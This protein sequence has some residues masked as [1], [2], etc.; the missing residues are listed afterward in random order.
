[1]LPILDEVAG[2]MA[3]SMAGSICSRPASFG[4]AG[5]FEGDG[6][7][8]IGGEDGDWGCKDVSKRVKTCSP[9]V[10]CA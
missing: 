4:I 3:G 1:M 10:H 7:D 5:M 8:V 2:S 6:I 9:C